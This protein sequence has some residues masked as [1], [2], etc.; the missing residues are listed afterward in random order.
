MWDVY[1]SAKALRAVKGF[2]KQGAAAKKMCA[3]ARDK[4]EYGGLAHDDIS[5][6][7]IDIGGKNGSQSAGGG[8]RLQSGGSKKGSFFSMCMGPS[9]VVE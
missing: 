1:E 5:V 4:R 6:I 7:V 8:G 2:S 9:D 3:H